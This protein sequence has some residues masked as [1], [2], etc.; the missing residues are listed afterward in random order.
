VAGLAAVTEPGGTLHLLCFSDEGPG[1]GPHP[2][3]R[4]ELAAAFGP[5]TG[6]HVATVE[7]DRV[8]TRFHGDD[9]APAWLATITR[10]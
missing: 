5:G 6:W 1:T 4:D 8:L 7:A 9:G 3:G 2:V 10:V